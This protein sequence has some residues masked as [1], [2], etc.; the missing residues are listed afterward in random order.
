MVSAI[1][2]LVSE[3]SL[4]SFCHPILPWPALHASARAAMIT[5]SLFNKSEAGGRLPRV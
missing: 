1:S 3:L 5:A 2:F 4:P